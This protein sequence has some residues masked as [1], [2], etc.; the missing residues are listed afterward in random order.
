M[1]VAQQCECTSYCGAIHLKM[2]NNFYMYFTTIKGKEVG[3]VGRRRE[4]GFYTFPECCS[5]DLKIWSW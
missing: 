4:F 5:S 3:E 2:I 1:M